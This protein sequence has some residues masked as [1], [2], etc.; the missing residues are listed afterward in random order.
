M[1]YGTGKMRL[2]AGFYRMDIKVLDEES[3][4]AAVGSLEDLD[5]V[6]R[7]GE[8]FGEELDQGLIGGVLDGWCGDADAEG[9]ILDAG[10][11]GATGPGDDFDV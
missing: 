3:F 6:F 1:G 2:E 8:G 7:A 5:G 11:F 10:A 9:I 4:L